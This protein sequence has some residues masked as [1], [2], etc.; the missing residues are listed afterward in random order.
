MDQKGPGGGMI[1]IK[2]IYWQIMSF[3]IMHTEVPA[4][5]AIAW[6]ESFGDDEA[7]YQYSMTMPKHH[8]TASVGVTQTCWIALAHEKFGLFD[9]ALRFCRLQLEPDLKKAG[10]PYM[11]WALTIALACKGRVLT[12]LNRHTEGLSAFQAAITSSKESY[13]MIEALAYRELAYC[14]G[15]AAVGVPV[16]IAQAA[17]QAGRDLEVRLKAFDGL[18]R[19]EFETL[20]ISP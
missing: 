14:C 20:M 17:S 3:L 12:K 7:F 13:P 6:L 2:L 9:G 15:D 5:K 11:K 19:A 1:S 16:E 10:T 8:H 18:T 4:S